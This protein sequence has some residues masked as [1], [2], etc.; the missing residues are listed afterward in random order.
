VASPAAWLASVHEG[1]DVTGTLL[2]AVA[3]ELGLPA[4]IPLAA[5]G[6]DNAAAAVGTGIVRTGLVSSSI[7]T[8]GVVFAHG[9]EFAPDPSGRVHAFCHAVPGRYHLMGVM[10]SAGGPPRGGRGPPWAGPPCRVP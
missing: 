6:G 7:G 5:G 9:D 4:G 3:A 8:S 2:P 1:P 10:L